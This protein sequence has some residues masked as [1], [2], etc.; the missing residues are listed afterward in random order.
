MG[1]SIYVA[2]LDT[3][4]GFD[5]LDHNL[6]LYNGFAMEYMMMYMKIYTESIFTIKV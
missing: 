3:D 2:Y 5:S 1:N 6:L 4:T